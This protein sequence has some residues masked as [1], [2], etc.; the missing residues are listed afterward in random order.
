ME[1]TSRWAKPNTIYR[2]ADA[3]HCHYIFLLLP[4]TSQLTALLIGPYLTDE[5]TEQQI[6][7][8]AEHLGIPARQFSQVLKS[9]SSI[10]AIKDHGLLHTMITAF[11][12]ILWGGGSAFEILDINQDLA[13]GFTP[14]HGV[15]NLSGPDELLLRMNIMEQRYAYENELIRIVSQGL[16]HRAEQMFQ[17]FSS[18]NFE[19][20]MED[21]ARNMKNYCIICNTL[22]RKAVEQGGVHPVYLDSVS[23]DFARKIESSPSAQDIQPLLLDMIRSYCRLVKKH[24]MQNYSSLIQR[25][26]TYID[27]DISGDLRLKALAEAQGVN[28]SYLSTLFKKE[29]GETITDHV[30][31]KRMERAA[32][33][34]QSTK[35]QIQSVAQHC[36]I[37]DV[38]Y[39]SKLFKKHLGL[40]PREFRSTTAERLKAPTT[41][42]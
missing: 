18:L 5:L 14:L 32:H 36:G 30:N 28:A 40:T 26:I 8:E 39:F 10:P 1:E 12:E 41:S 17:G 15:R 37:S 33:L 2:V 20:R 23:S 7:E 25:T 38:N 42:E 16:I 9:Y 35:L 24:S 31:K 4:N 3:F 22:M 6:L 29:T 27:A 21:S 11:G 19:Q 13:L 34:L